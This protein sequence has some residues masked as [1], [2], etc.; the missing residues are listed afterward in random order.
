MWGY[1][2]AQN[3]F[4]CI[5]AGTCRCK[6]D[7]PE[8]GW[9]QKRMRQ[10]SVWDNEGRADPLE[11]AF[12]QEASPV[13]GDDFSCSAQL[14]ASSPGVAAPVLPKNRDVM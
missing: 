11:V 13:F 9:R 14:A 2:G 6:P 8:V 10:R 3:K 7:L 1:P 12:R 5:G 4:N